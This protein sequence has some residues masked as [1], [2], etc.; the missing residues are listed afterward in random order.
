MEGLLQ[1]FRNL[2]AARLLAMAATMAAS[3]VFFI[4]LTTRLTTP[5]LVPLSGPL[6]L[7]EA[8]KVAAKLDT[9]GVAYTVKGNGGVLLVPEDQV[10]RLRMTL[11]RDGLPSGGGIGNEL[12][13]K[14]SALGMTSFMQ[15]VN[16]VRALEGELARTI[17]TLSPVASARVHLVLAK[18]EA[19]SRE[20][21]EASASVVLSMRGGARLDR[22]QVQAIQHLVAS[23]VKDLKPAQISII[24]ERGTL[25]AKGGGDGGLLGIGTAQMEELRAGHETRLRQAIVA[26]LEPVL[27][28]GK[29]RAVVAVDLEQ[30]R[31][32]SQ[33]KTFDS[34]NPVLRSTQSVEEN[35]N[36][37]ESE[38]DRTVTAQNNLPEAQKGQGG[39]PKSATSNA[40]TEKTENFEIGESTVSQVR[41]AGGIKRVSVAV[42][43]D[44][45][46]ALN[47]EGKRSYTPRDEETLKKLDNLVRSAVMFTE[48]RGDRVEVANLRFVDPKEEAIANGEITPEPFLSLSKSDYFRIGEIA[49][50]L[51]LGALVLL[52]VVRPLVARLLKPGEAQ[53]SGAQALQV[54]MTTGGAA[55]P[56]LPRPEGEAADGQLALQGATASNQAQLPNPDSMIDMA[57]VEGRVKQ[58]SLTKVGEIVTRHPDQALTIVR[59]WLHEPAR[60]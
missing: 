42:L 17:R 32:T 26:A 7:E 23:S 40:R 3:V 24:D 20:L 60:T 22:G 9:L 19:F 57:Q 46:Y 38:Q 6:D 11:A 41:E 35:S 4:W 36:S 45:T 5:N 44:G 28:A 29:V 54:T 13:D 56:S 30:E 59:N 53:P 55:Q 39:G 43:V 1:L 58:S 49:A 15:D 51:L 2:G 52:L 21:P 34:E 8:G 31:V 14:D 48:A 50:L 27:G 12:L 37:N 47:A 25:L 18:R 33:K 10:A 16:K